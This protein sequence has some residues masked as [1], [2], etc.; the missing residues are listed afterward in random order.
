MHRSNSLVV[1]MMERIFKEEGGTRTLIRSIY[2]HPNNFHINEQ[3]YQLLLRLAESADEILAEEYQRCMR[4]QLKTLLRG[5]LVF[6]KNKKVVPMHRGLH[7]LDIL[8]K[9]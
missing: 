1:S 7:L 3:A 8:L 4:E 2:R 6:D 9:D 5:I